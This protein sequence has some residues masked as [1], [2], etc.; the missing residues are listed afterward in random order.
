MHDSTPTCM[1]V[2]GFKGLGSDVLYLSQLMRLGASNNPILMVLGAILLYV[3]TRNLG[4]LDA[5]CMHPCVAFNTFC[6]FSM[7]CAV[8]CCAATG[9]VC[10]SL[11]T[12]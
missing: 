6:S 1:Q 5:T 12:L 11:L 10:L 7:C 2:R 3:R 8:L 9:K 4:A